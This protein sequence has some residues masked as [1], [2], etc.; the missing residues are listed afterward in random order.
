MEYK[1]IT[2]QYLKTLKESKP[3]FFKAYHFIMRLNCDS[4]IKLLLIIMMD[5]ANIN[6]GIIKWKHNTYADKLG[7]SI[8]QVQRLFKTLEGNGSIYPHKDNHAG[9]KQ[10]KFAI[11][12]SQ[13]I[14]LYK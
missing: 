10:N 1:Q 6:K 12:L 7:I 4:T 9:G 8:R 11:N 13:I 14:K 5:D 3:K 2:E